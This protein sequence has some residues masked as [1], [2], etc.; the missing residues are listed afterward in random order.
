MPAKRSKSISRPSRVVGIDPGLSKTTAGG[1]ALVVDKQLVDAIDMPGMKVGNMSYPVVDGLSVRRFI[2]EAD[3]DEIVIEMVGAR[4]KQGVSS[5]FKFG[6]AY[7]SVVGVALSTEK[8]VRL[9]TP[10]VWKKRAGLIAMP[11][12]YALD[13]AKTLWPDLAHLFRLKKYIGRADASL[14]AVYG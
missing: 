5:T 13:T 14:I 6:A 4:P 10:S 3:P 2:E 1:L 12:N 8:P 11:K 9:V 7:G